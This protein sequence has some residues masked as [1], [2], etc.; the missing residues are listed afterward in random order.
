MVGRPREWWPLSDT[1]PVPGNAETLA[2]LGQQM[3][4][5]AAEIESMAAALPKLSASE[6]WDSASGQQFRNKAATTATGIGKAHGRFRAVATALGSSTVGGT[7]T[8]PPSRNAKTG[9]TRRSR[10]STAR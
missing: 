2:G 3:A 9:R 8:P 1:D 10:L 4:N 7:A 6:L 5:A